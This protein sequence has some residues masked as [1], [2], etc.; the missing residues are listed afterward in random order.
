MLKKSLLSLRSLFFIISCISF[1]NY[2]LRLFFHLLYHKEYDKSA[3]IDIQTFIKV[4]LPIFSSTVRLDFEVL[5]LSLVRLENV[6]T[7]RLTRVTTLSNLW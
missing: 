6:K 5:S 1:Y 4:Y 3:E 7:L 2:P